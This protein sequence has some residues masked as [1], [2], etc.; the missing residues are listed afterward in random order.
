MPS[1]RIVFSTFRDCMS[2]YTAR[3]I[4]NRGARKRPLVH[5]CFAPKA[6]QK[7]DPAKKRRVSSGGRRVTGEDEVAIFG[8]L[9]AGEASFVQRLVARFA[10]LEVG[11]SPAVSRGVLL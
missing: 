8:R 4:S 7:I 5:V 9:V 11:K 3:V 6:V 10:V 2:F 1:W